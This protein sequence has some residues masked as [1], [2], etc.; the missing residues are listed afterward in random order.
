MSINRMLGAKKMSQFFGG[1]GDNG[2]IVF[3]GQITQAS[4]FPTLAEVR[5]GWE[6]VIN[7]PSGVIDNDPAKTN[8]GLTFSDKNFIVWTGLTW[9]VEGSES[10]V[11]D[12]GQNISPVDDR[13]FDVT[14]GKSYNIDGDDAVT[15]TGTPTI[16]A[17]GIQS[18]VARVKSPSSQMWKDFLEPYQSPSFTSFNISG[19]TVLECGYKIVGVQNFEWTISNIDNVQDNTVNIDDITIDPNINLVTGYNKFDVPIFAYNFNSYPT[20]GLQYDVPEV[21]VWRI[22]ATNSQS[23]NFTRDFGLQWQ[24]RSYAGSNTNTTLTNAQVLALSYHNLSESFP[25]TIVFAGAGYFQYFI[26]SDF[27]Q[28]TSFIDLNTGYP[29]GVALIG[30]QTITNSLGVETLYNQYRSTYFLTDGTTVKIS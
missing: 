7:N 4:D 22:Q 12:D 13:G 27:V 30:T 26:P 28:P 29:M 5:I 25:E 10:L 19:A 18:G 24:L 11:K 16:T 21:H 6:Y 17:G 14:A 2:S 3:K 8:T 1:S 9:A 15:Y 23:N 20:G